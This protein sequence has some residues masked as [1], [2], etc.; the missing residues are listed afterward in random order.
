VT[1]P[2][3]VWDVDGTLVDSRATITASV[4]AGFRAIGREPPPYDRLRRIVGLTLAPALRELAP[5]LSPAEQA[6]LIEGYRAKYLEIAEAPEFVE[7]LYDGA[8]ETLDRLKAD[9]WAIAIATGKSR[10]GLERIVRMHGWADLFDS[11]HCADDGPGKPD[12][13]MLVEAMRV[14]RI[15]R[16]ATVMIGDT[17]H[18]MRM[19]KAAGVR[20]QGVA[21]GFHTVEEVVAAGAD[22]VAT[23]W[24]ELNAALDRFG[25]GAEEP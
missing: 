6:G 18:D 4:Q 20:A 13:A 17:S 2:L 8:A 11:T 23:T 19:A 12:P 14:L 24:A 9:G 1:R 10:R 16:D 22:A 5:E 15:P 25:A 21:W 3:A 7:A